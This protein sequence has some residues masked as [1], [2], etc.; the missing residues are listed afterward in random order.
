VRASRD[1]VQQAQAALAAAKLQAQ[2]NKAGDVAAAR[3]DAA[4]RLND[5]RYA[6]DQVAR[7]TITAPYSGIVQTIAT[8]STDSLRPLQIGDVVTAGQP[9][10]TLA[11]E[12]GF[13]VRA[14]VDEQDIAQ[15]R[16]G[17]AARISGEDLGDRTLT[18]HIVSV[19]EVA[20][21]SDDPSNT[22]RQIIT[23]IKL[24]RSL[25]FLRDGMNVDVDIVTADRPHVIAIA[26]DAIR[27]DDAKPYVLTVR[28][29][30]SRTV[31]TPVVLGASNDTDTIVRSG[32]RPGDVVVVD[33]NPAIV[34]DVAVKAAPS[35]S[36]APSASGS[37]A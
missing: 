26:T 16:I 32:L 27:R 19:G 4:A 8:Q 15:V 37:A 12:G 21:K 34:E 14:R 18:G 20:Q 17:E 5:L 29:I 22:S 7:L 11:A 23:T 25:P 24:D 3:G 36:P 2:Q 31:K 1:A 9:V 33:T 28:P 30:D 13:I 35:P 6:E 10:V